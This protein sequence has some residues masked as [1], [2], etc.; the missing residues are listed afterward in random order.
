MITETVETL[1]G[2]TVDEVK[3]SYDE[4]SFWLYIG[5]ED[6]SVLLSPWNA[7]SDLRVE[8]TGNITDLTGS[9]ITKAEKVIDAHETQNG[10]PRAWTFY[11]FAT[12]KGEVT[13]RWVRCESVKV[14][15]RSHEWVR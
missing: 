5:S 9:P 13:V 10:Y 3:V 1:I 15:E 2:A 12:E 14:T 6:S 8:D 11:R 4:N 7:H